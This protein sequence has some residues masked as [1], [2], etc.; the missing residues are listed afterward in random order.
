MNLSETHRNITFDSRETNIEI[1]NKSRNVNISWYQ[2]F[3]A[4]QAI[5]ELLQNAFESCVRCNIFFM[6]HYLRVSKF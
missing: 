6:F 1:I 4:I 3:G 5:H 2:Y